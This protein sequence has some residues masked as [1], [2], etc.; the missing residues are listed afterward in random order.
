M[1]NKIAE[2]P[3][4]A[5]WVRPVL[6]KRDRIIK[7]VKTKYWDKRIKYGIA[8]PKSVKEALEIDEMTGT[9]FWR[10]AI[11]KEMKNVAVAFE[12]IDGVVVPP[13]YQQIP[14]HMIFDVKLDLTRKA[15]YVA[16]GHKTEVPKEHTF[17]SVVSRD[18][19]RLMFMLAALN[20]LEVQSADFQNA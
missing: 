14:C 19:V 10:D 3:A 8:M 15:R 18:S 5:W 7:K 4:F 1:N 6:K 17:S 16:G 13:G 12:F 20:D 2:E 9:T 11:E